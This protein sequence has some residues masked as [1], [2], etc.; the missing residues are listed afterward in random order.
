MKFKMRSTT[1]KPVEAM[2][3]QKIPSPVMEAACD[4]CATADTAALGW[5]DKSDKNQ[6]NK[7]NTN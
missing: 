1:K 2:L 4:F 7:S 3:M 6:I 5:I